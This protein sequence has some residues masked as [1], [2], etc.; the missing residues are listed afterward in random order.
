MVEL[1]TIITRQNGV[2]LRQ[3]NDNL[4]CLASLDAVCRSQNIFK[5]HLQL[6]LED[7]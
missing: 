2:Q 4:S 6:E 3:P 1:Q 7:C 5:I